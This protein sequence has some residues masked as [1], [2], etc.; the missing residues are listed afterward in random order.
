[1]VT[2]RGVGKMLTKARQMI[3]NHVPGVLSTKSGTEPLTFDKSFNHVF[4]GLTVFGN[5]L[6]IGTGDKTPDNPY[7]FK[8]FNGKVYSRRKTL[9]I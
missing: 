2:A 5:T 9:L 6:E 4:T 3:F 7:E 8:S 1:M